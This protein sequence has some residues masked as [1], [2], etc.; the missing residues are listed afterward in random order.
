MYRDRIQILE[1]FAETLRDLQEIISSQRKVPQHLKRDLELM[2]D[3][4]DGCLVLLHDLRNID[5]GEC[6][7]VAYYGDQETNEEKDGEED[8][9]NKEEYWRRRGAF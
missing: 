7:L 3:L 9:Y 1:R 2:E 5:K 8:P 4:I 6:H